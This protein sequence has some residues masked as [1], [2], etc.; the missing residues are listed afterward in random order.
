M[1]HPEALH[2]DPRYYDPST[3]PIPHHLLAIRHAGRIRHRGVRVCLFFYVEVVGDD[4]NEPCF[5][6]LIGARG[7]EAVS[8]GRGR[9]GGEGIGWGGGTKIGHGRDG[10]GVCGWE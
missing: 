1:R 2:S 7:G 5:E 3:F 8:T 4:G 6:S 9:V 10:R